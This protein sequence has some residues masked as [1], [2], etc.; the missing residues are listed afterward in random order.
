M[1][2]ILNLKTTRYKYPPPTRNPDKTDFKVGDM[3][4]IKNHTPKDAFD[5][6]YK[7]SFCI[8]KRILDK[9]FDVQDS[10]GK[11]R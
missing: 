4:L 9:A 2:V 5:S 3:V 8:C 10:T 11:V 1:M 6:K 7:P